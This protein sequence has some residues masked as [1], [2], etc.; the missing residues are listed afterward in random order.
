MVKYRGKYIL[1][2]LDEI[3]P[4]MLADLDLAYDV[5]MR[6]HDTSE[7]KMCGRCCHQ[8]NIVIMDNETER[9]AKHINMGNEEFIR[10]FL[11]RRDDRWLFKKSGRCHFLGKDDKCTIWR[12]RPEICRDFPYLVAKFMSRVYLSIV[13]GVDIDLSYMDDS[14]PCTAVIKDSV[15]VLI[16]DAQRKKR[17]SQDVIVK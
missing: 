5:C 9:I 12:E 16:A 3:P 15:G 4:D 1:E 8:P 13:N 14:W 2:G 10:N 6:I 11:Y 17:I 7:C